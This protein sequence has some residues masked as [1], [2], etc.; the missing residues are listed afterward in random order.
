MRVSIRATGLLLSRVTRLFSVALATLLVAGCVTAPLPPAGIGAR[1]AWSALPGW[2]TERHAAAW[3]ALMANCQKMPARDAR[4]RSICDDAALF[5]EPSDDVARA[6]FE[7]RFAPYALH[8]DQGGVDGLITGYYE[9]LLNGSR[10]RSARYRYPIYRRPDDLLVVD[11]GELYPELAGRP[12]RGRL[13]GKRVVPYFSRAEITAGQGGANAASADR[14]RG[15]ELLWVDDPVA[16]FF[17]QVQGSGRVQLPDGSVV[18][19]GYADQN[20]HPYQSIGA[21]LVAMGALKRDEVSLDSIRAWLAAHP[22][23]AEGLLNSNPS[24]VF[25][26]LREAPA[27]ASLDGPLGSLGV[28]LTAER[29]AAVDPSFIALGSP[30]WLDTSLPGEAARPYRRLLIAQDTGG[31]IKG[32]VRADVFFGHGAQAEY[33]AGHMKQPGRLFVL[34]PETR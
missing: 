4:W 17:L 25:F 30:L 22:D 34:L 6:F 28:P 12:V 1:V 27:D 8:N 24:F 32:A 18:R 29:S 7:T 21:R 33:L 23:E 16:L 2:E 13:Q 5:G 26:A 31:A 10:V 11:L 14:L 20:G 15:N 9:P 3:P 19:V